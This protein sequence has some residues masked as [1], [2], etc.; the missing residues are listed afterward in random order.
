MHDIKSPT[1]SQDFASA[2]PTGS[3]PQGPRPAGQ[4]DA[5][6]AL[7]ALLA[8]PT[9]EVRRTSAASG[10]VV[11][12]PTA[13][14]RTVYFILRGQ[15]RL[16]QEDEQGS[17]RLCEILGADEWFGVGALAGS[18]TYEMRAIAV[19]PSVVAEV[20]ADKLMAAL[21]RRPEVLVE[22]NRQLAVKLQAARGEAAE[23]I[24]RDTNARLVNTLI[25]FS[26]SAASTPRDDGV[27]LNITHSQLAQAV[28][29]ARETISLA[30]SQLRLRKLVRT[31]RNQLFFNPDALR[32]MRRELRHSPS[33][34]SPQAPASRQSEIERVA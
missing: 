18:E 6:A 13:P 30:L 20:R 7:Q 4:T 27:V 14:A 8:D 5:L 17:S 28:G 34:S 3:G 26:R 10:T 9:L 22:L 21:S 16:Y 11:F 32:S 19:V 29:A 2:V 33:S 12:E 24:F 23:L 15:V 1:P 31:G 25:R